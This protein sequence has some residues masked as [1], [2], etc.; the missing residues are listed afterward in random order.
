MCPEDTIAPPDPVLAVL[1]EVQVHFASFRQL[2]GVDD[3]W[4]LTRDRIKRT[5]ERMGREDRIVRAQYEGKDVTCLAWTDGAFWLLPEGVEKYAA[6]I[7]ETRAAGDGAPTQPVWRMTL[8]ELLVQHT[9]NLKQL[10]MSVA[11][12]LV[13]IE[14]LRE[15]LPTDHTMLKNEF[16]RC[17]RIVGDLIEELLKERERLGKVLGNNVELYERVLITEQMLERGEISEESLGYS[18]QDLRRAQSRIRDLCQ[19]ELTV[20]EHVLN[21]ARGRVQEGL[22]GGEHTQL[23]RTSRW[24]YTFHQFEEAPSGFLGLSSLVSFERRRLAAI[25]AS[26]E[27][28]L[29]ESEE[30][31]T[32][33]QTAAEIDRP[34]EPPPEEPTPPPKE[35][36]PKEVKKKL[37]RRMATADRHRR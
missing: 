37:V 12:D 24:D 36:A 29:G 20:Y 8:R 4:H 25:V 34:K 28:E 32:L 6:A 9:G 26:R 2:T 11:Y 16:A 33:L 30:G 3:P 23:T 10:V 13:A 15:K 1:Y 5:H 19:E 31:K 27:K 14:S 22:R 17:E 18:S 35:E 7:E 21:V